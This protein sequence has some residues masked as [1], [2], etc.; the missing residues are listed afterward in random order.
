[1][2]GLDANVVVRHL[3]DDDPVQSPVAHACFDGLSLHEPGFVSIVTLAEVHWVLRQSYRFSR[4]LV[5]AAIGRLLSASDL[6]IGDADIAR[7]ALAAAEETGCDFPDALIVQLGVAAGCGET[8]TFDRKA[9]VI[10]GIRL[11]G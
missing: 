4:E 8:V 5:H 6:V 10:D 9:G 2:I 7:R 11:L 1:M 3:V